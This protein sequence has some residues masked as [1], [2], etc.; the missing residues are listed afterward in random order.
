V[1]DWRPSNVLILVVLLAGAGLFLAGLLGGGDDDSS[2]SSGTTAPPPGVIVWAVGNGADANGRGSAV[3]RLVTR[4]RPARF[5]YLGGV[6]PTGVLRDFTRGYAQAFGRLAAF[7]APTVGQPEYRNRGLGYDPYWKAVS[8]AADKPA[9]ASFAK[10]AA[11]DGPPAYYTFK[12]GGWDILAL[13]SEGAHDKGSKQV[14][15]LRKQVA[16][17]KGTCRLAFWYTS[18]YSAGPAP[19]AQDVEPF[20]DALRNRAVLVLNAR[21][22]N[23]QRISQRGITQLTAG[24]GG[25]GLQKAPNGR[26]LA[27]FTNDT[28]YGALRLDL[29]ATSARYSFVA[30]D[31]RTLDTGTV[32]C[33]PSR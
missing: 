8:Q 18:R 1:G 7:T 12:I 24:S 11:K 29:R 21:N 30:V 22:R 28:R 31:G 32:P 20:W 6:F 26:K 15:W 13:D 4:G 3:A 25:V 9:I 27:T 5:L 2:E 23:M 19:D 10:E 16:K 17:G 14:K 33:R